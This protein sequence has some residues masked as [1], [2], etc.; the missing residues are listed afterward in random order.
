MRTTTPL[1]VLALLLP[2][3][4]ARLDVAADD[5]G[6]DTGTPGDSAIDIGATCAPSECGGEPG[7]P[8]PCWDGSL[9]ADICRRGTDGVCRWTTTGCPPPKKCVL[10][11][12]SCAS[13]QYCKFDTCPAAGSTGTCAV[14]PTACSKLYDPVCGCD[15]VT[16]NNACAAAV[17]GVSLS[18]IGACPTTGSCSSNAEC[19]KA[20]FCKMADGLC[21]APLPGGG[22][23]TPPA[24]AGKCTKRPTGCP[25]LWDPVCGCTGATY[26]NRC[27]AESA[28]VNVMHTGTCEGPPPPPPG[29]SCGGFG[30]ASCGPTEWCD[31]PASSCGGADEIGKCSPRPVACPSTYAPVCGCNGKTYVNECTAQSN[32]IDI[33]GKGPC[34]GA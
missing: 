21:Y 23:P 33:S 29:G 26:G 24:P 27:D 3:C 12:S 30:G 32:G 15:H 5:G 10:G 9:P 34:K 28:G 17:A 18:L 6:T 31:Y 16:Y 13:G 11:D 20:E 1:F 22:G 19:G 2:A 25:D 14:T 8:L 7:A 4:G